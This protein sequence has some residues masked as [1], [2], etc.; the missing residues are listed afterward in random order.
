MNSPVSGDRSTE[1]KHMQILIRKIM[2]SKAFGVFLFCLGG[3]LIGA[4]GFSILRGTE[5]FSQEEVKGFPN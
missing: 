4:V 5:A 2:T 1:L 3:L